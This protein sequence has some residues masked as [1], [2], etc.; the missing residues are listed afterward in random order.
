MFNFALILNLNNNIFFFFF[1]Q[2][3]YL[4]LLKW[5][6]TRCTEKYNKNQR[7]RETLPK[8][9]KYND[10]VCQ[11]P[12]ENPSLKLDDQWLKWTLKSFSKHLNH[13]QVWNRASSMTFSGEK[14]W[15]LKTILFL[16]FQMVIGRAIQ[17]A[18]HLLS[19]LL[20]KFQCENCKKWFFGSIGKGPT[21]L[22][23]LMASHQRILVFEQLNITWLVVSSSESHKGQVYDGRSTCL[24]LKLALVGILFLKSLHENAFARGGICK[25]QT[26]FAALSSGTSL[27]V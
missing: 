27:Y 21:L 7:H 3:K 8:K 5:F 22:T 17:R 20:C 19:V 12:L 11:P 9:G 26:I 6:S 1:A 16:C 24:L 23:Q 14:S 15:L 13:D 2:Q 4:I 10:R 18:S 25:D